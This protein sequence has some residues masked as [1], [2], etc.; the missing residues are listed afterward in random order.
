MHALGLEALARLLLGGIRRIVTLT[1]EC[2]KCPDGKGLAIDQR[3]AELIALL[4]DRGLP[5]MQTDPTQSVPRS[6]PRLMAWAAVHA[7]RRTFLGF[8]SPGARPERPASSTLSRLQSL[9][10][11]A[12]ARTAFAPR[13][14]TQTCTGVM[15]AFASV[16]R[17]PIP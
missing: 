6:M 4:A 17:V 9:R 11:D 14:D 5:P 15:P 10:T 8:G 1:A 3:I 13:I 16:P 7:G 12:T 2:A